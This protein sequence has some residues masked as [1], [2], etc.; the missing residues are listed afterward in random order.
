MLDY[1]AQTYT[2]YCHLL[3]CEMSHVGRSHFVMAAVAYSVV[4]E[5]CSGVI[6]CCRFLDKVL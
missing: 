4:N 1:V 2:Q 3:R 5:L 6:Y